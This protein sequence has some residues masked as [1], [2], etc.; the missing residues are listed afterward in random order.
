MYM[1]Q[2]LLKLSFIEVSF[3]YTMQLIFK[4]LIGIQNQQRLNCIIYNFLYVSGCLSGM[5]AGL[6]FVGALK[7]KPCSVF[8]VYCFQQRVEQNG[9]LLGLLTWGIYRKLRPH[10]LPTKTI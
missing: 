1:L 6:G 3:V 8:P 9:P 7:G 2:V 4:S 5:K 10:T